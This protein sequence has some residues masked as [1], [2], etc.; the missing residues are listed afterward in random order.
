[1]FMLMIAVIFWFASFIPFVSFL[2]NIASWAVFWLW[3]KL[4]GA[5]LSKNA[6]KNILSLAVS[7]IP[8]GDV[9]AAFPVVIYINIRTVRKEDD[10][11]NAQMLAQME[12]D[13]M[14]AM[15]YARAQRIAEAQMQAQWE[16]EQAQADQNAEQESPE[17]TNEEGEYV[18]EETRRIEAE[19]ERMLDKP[20]EG[21]ENARFETVTG[22]DAFDRLKNK[23][24]R[25]KEEDAR[26]A[27]AQ[28][29]RATG[30]LPVGEH[31]PENVAAAAQYE[32]ERTHSR[33]TRRITPTQEKGIGP[34]N[35]A[36]YEE[37]R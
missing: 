14:E 2:I 36:Q 28:K 27:R 1:M 33:Q 8:F 10:E 15:Q 7:L 6:G 22:E 18:D 26:L 21:E 11:F 25:T 31:T 37:S 30:L 32:Y 13:R 19:Q 20:E 12:Q 34:A 35:D 24:N 23:P 3:F 5:T 4:H 9:L 16:E 17:K 29:I